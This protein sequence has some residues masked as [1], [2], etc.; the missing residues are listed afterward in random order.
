MPGEYTVRNIS[1][2]ATMEIKA[3]FVQLADG[4]RTGVIRLQVMTQEFIRECHEPVE[5][6]VDIL[7]FRLTG[8]VVSASDKKLER[9]RLTGIRAMLEEKFLCQGRRQSDSQ[10][11]GVG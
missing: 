2:G 9:R 1:A 11:I 6:L 10:S 4:L 5:N 3:A 8:P 7:T